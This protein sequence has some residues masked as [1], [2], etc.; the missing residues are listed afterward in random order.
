MVRSIEKLWYRLCERHAKRRVETSPIS[1]PQFIKNIIFMEY[2]TLHSSI[3]STVGNTPL[4]GLQRIIPPGGARVLVK[5]EFFNPLS[6]VKDRIGLAM[7]EHAEHQGELHADSHI[8]EPTSGNTGVALA[9]V[10]A[11]KGYRLTLAIPESMSHERRALLRG[12][13]ADFVLTPA[14]EGMRGAVERAEELFD[15]F[16]NTWMPRQFD[17]PANPR[18]HRLTTGP[19]IWEATQG[20]V[21]IVVAGVG[22][23]GTITGVTEYLRQRKPSVRAIAVEPAESPVIS[24]GA[25]G[26]HGIQGIGAGFIPSNLN[27]SLLDGVEEVETEEAFYWARRLTREEGVLGGISSGANVAAAARVAAR[28]ENAGKTIVT[29]ASS[30]GERYL[31]TSLYELVGLPELPRALTLESFSPGVAM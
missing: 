31:S 10:A 4:V 27:T 24:G 12:L 9:F 8:I 19:E 21:D 23:G 15:S 16:P 3:L 7:V 26:K 25:P 30:A 22:T 13:G 14:E 18:V 11:A 17:N 5:C 2:S 1:R 29:F 20:E 28:P 6:S